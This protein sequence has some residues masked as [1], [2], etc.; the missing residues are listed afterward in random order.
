MFNNF[1]TARRTSARLILWSLLVFFLL[2]ALIGGLEALLG[3]EAAP[4]VR[5]PA[6]AA[7]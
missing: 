3:G 7:R 2:S 5:P 4:G 1:R 6:A